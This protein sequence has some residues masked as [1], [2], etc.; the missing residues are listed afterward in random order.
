M[1]KDL[2]LKIQ[3]IEAKYGG[4]IQSPA[5]ANAI[6][7]MVHK[8]R[9]ELDCSKLPAGYLEFLKVTNGLDFNGLVIYGVDK[10]LISEIINDQMCGFVDTNKIWYDNEW[11]KRFL[12]F[13][14][15]DVAWYCLDR[16]KGIYLE[17]DKPSGTPMSTYEDFDAMLEDALKSRLI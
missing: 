4:G 14:D 12:F 5:D 9:E 7:Q 3:E 10:F 8:V 11:Q 13:G 6:R 17:L 16:I 1:W 15:S 2:L